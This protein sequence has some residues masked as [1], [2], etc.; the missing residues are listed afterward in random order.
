MEIVYL[1]LVG[2]AGYLCG[3]IA[4]G[5]ACRAMEPFLDRRR[6]KEGSKVGCIRCGTTIGLLPNGMCMTCA[7]QDH[8][9][10]AQAIAPPLQQQLFPGYMGRGFSSVPDAP[11][12]VPVPDGG[13][14]AEDRIGWRVWRLCGCYLTSYS[15]GSMW[16]PGEV[17]EGDPDK[18]GE[19]V[20][21]F[22]DLRSAFGLVPQGSLC[23][24]GRV[25]LWGVVVAHERGWR[26]QYAKVVGIDDIMNGPP[27]WSEDY[28]RA[29]ARLR[30]RYLED[31]HG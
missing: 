19:G 10:R 15:A 4:V 12:P 3:Y 20:H 21:A 5:F 11:K 16:V 22:C 1:A 25:Q 13:I 18:P 6:S 8:V 9:T 14:V 30:K 2:L 28:D 7:Y 26:A 23:V 31:E 24:V 27:M 29:L 17:M